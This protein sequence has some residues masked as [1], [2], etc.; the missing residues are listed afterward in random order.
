MSDDFKNF[1]DNIDKQKQDKV[2]KQ[3]LW[4]NSVTELFWKIK[5]WFSSTPS[6][7]VKE[8][9][10]PASREDPYNYPQMLQIEIGEIKIGLYPYSQGVTDCIGYLD[11]SG[12][13][14]KK[15]L[16]FTNEKTWTIGNA[17][18]KTQMQQVQSALENLY[19]TKP[20]KP[21]I[22]ELTEETF[23]QALMEI[24]KK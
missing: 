11:M 17:D 15:K 18:Y 9:P 24:C 7:K 21:E 10:S 8:E 22:E 12:H 3:Q 14:G 19:N 1:V 2:D 13:N 16:K 4:K 23:K 6:V 5:S 20:P